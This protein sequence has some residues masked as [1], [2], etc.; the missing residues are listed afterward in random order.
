[1]S[2][3]YGDRLKLAL[4]HSGKS[5]AEL[6]R[7]LVSPTGRTGVSE[8][9]VHQVLRGETRSQTAENCALAARFLGV[10]YYWLATGRGS[11]LADAPVPATAG[12]PPAAYR[13]TGAATL[14]E[15]Q[16]MLQ[17][18]APEVRS[19]IADILASWARNGGSDER[20]DAVLGLLRV[21]SKLQA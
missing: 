2:G 21:Q 5:V 7:Q 20:A 3:T 1:M 6:A 19:S 15:L 17:A 18:A 12:E 16:L 8:T 11:M 9:S 10:S 13:A 14:Q 4:E